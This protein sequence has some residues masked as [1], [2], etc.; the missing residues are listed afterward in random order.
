MSESI[1][2]AAQV[3]AA[4]ILARRCEALFESAG[5][6]EGAAGH[7]FRAHDL[8]GGGLEHQEARLLALLGAAKAAGGTRLVWK[9]PLRVRDDAV[10]ARFCV[11]DK[12]GADVTPQ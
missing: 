5:T 1:R 12:D 3:A 2:H 6:D 9:E 8:V 10:L 4:E 11:L 7:P